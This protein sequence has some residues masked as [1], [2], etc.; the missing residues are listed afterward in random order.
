MRQPLPIMTMIA[1]AFSQWVT[2]AKRECTATAWRLARLVLI[3]MPWP[4]QREIPALPELIYHCPCSAAR[5]ALRN[6]LR[7]LAIFCSSIRQRRQVVAHDL[8]KA[9]NVS[10]GVF[11]LRVVRFMSTLKR[12][13]PVDPHARN[14]ILRHCGDGQGLSTGAG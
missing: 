3:A 12:R 1:M 5:L 9:R 14:C 11:E 4:L 2:R 10:N 6:L 8:V 13:T 7:D